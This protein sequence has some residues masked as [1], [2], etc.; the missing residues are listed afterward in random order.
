MCFIHR[1]APLCQE[2]IERT[3]Y[4]NQHYVASGKIGVQYNKMLSSAFQIRNQSDYNDFYVVISRA[5]AEKQLNDAAQFIDFI[6]DY[7]QKLT[8]AMVNK[9]LLIHCLF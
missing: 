5:E 6:A 2:K 1:L 4:F 7:I 3:G 9:K 8:E